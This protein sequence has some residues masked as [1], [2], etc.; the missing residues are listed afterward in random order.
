L[1]NSGKIVC[2]PRDED[3]KQKFIIF[4]KSLS[5]LKAV[6]S[7]LIGKTILVDQKQNQALIKSFKEE[8]TLLNLANVSSAELE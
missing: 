4:Q 5:S 8:N 7:E 3:L 2:N 6:H 1:Q